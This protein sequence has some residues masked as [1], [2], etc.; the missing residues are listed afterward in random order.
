MS[1]FSLLINE[2]LPKN[3]WQKDEPLSAHSS[4]RIGGNADYFAR[5]ADEA[6]FTALIEAAKVSK[7]P[8]C[9]IGSG[10]NILFS[11]KGFRG[12][13]ITTHGLKNIEINGTAVRAGSG[14]TLP[15]LSS[16][17][18]RESLDGM[19]FM[20]GIPG[21]VG[22][23]VFMNAGAYGGEI[24][25][26]LTGSRYYDTDSGEICE[27]SANEHDFAY[28]HSSYMDHPE[29]II[30]SADFALKNGDPDEIKAECDE[31]LRRRAEK[32][33]LEFPSAG[34]TFKRYPGFFT[35]QLIDECGL[36]GYTVG[37]AQ[38]SQ[39]HAGFVINRGGATAADVLALVDH[40]K[41]VIRSKHGIDIECEI[42]F[43]GEM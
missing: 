25:D 29:R 19:R 32:Q 14:V 40:I 10:S 20:C 24:S 28:R 39:K 8:F 12:V 36:K 15:I 17:A 18:Q 34:S 6:S 38:V 16:K 11:D 22:G 9:V 26:I 33:P 43:I 13:I 37:G 21:T 7:T 35:A 5:P 27:L 2:I 4:F 3:A 31:L 42:R 30:L 1:D 41:T 23:G